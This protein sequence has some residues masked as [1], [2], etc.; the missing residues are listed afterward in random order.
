MKDSNGSLLLFHKI[1]GHPLQDG[2]A[3]SAS[4]QV[5][6]ELT[7]TTSM[8]LYVESGAEED[9]LPLSKKRASEDCKP[10]TDE[11][12]SWSMYALILELT[13]QGQG[14][15]PGRRRAAD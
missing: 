1:P 12:I 6:S 7:T 13:L 15:H 4:G 8:S 14:Q 2:A 11:V 10:D 9:G 5:E 3:T